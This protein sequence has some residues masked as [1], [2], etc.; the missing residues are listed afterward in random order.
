M[1]ILIPKSLLFIDILN[2]G[3]LKSGF[4]KG[5]CVCSKTDE[6]EISLDEVYDHSFPNSLPILTTG[7]VFVFCLND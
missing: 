6:V 5:L 4:S 1:Y 2:K 7:I 3:F